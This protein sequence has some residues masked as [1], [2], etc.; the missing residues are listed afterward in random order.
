MALPGRG[1]GWKEFFSLLGVEYKRDRVSEVAGALTFFSVLALFPFLLFMVALA[2]LI[3][4]PATARALVD[5]LARVAPSEVTEIIGERIEALGERSSVGL[6]TIGAAVAFYSASRGIVAAMKAFNTVYGVAESRPF[7]KV[8]LIAF[9][10]TF[11]AAVLG[12]LAALVAVAT[13]AAASALGEPAGAV[14]NGLR[15]PVAGLTMMLLWALLYFFLPDVEQEFRFI[16][17]G[18][19]V[20]VLIWLL[21][22]WGFSLYVARFGE[23]DATYG[24]LGGG[25]VLLLWMWISSLLLLL[26]AEINAVVEHKSPEGKG[27]GAR[28]VG[29]R[30][31]RATKTEVEDSGGAL[32]VSPPGAPLAVSLELD[33]R[34][35]APEAAVKKSLRRRTVELLAGAALV[36]TLVCLARAPSP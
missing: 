32:P 29:R 8:Q 14:L 15:L 11:A 22:S 20:G 28:R 19:V 1:M 36:G 23:Y 25:I 24:A 7:W 5:Q 35:R 31:P 4:D 6:L 26:G 33:R 21:A 12:I 3:I 34:R 2:S 17:P 30:L 10:M 16:T 13:P 27:A 9:A 18:S